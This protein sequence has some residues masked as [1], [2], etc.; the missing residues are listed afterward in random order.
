MTLRPALTTLLTLALSACAVA[1]P[2]ERRA[3][4]DR[5]AAA[6]ALAPLTLQTEKF[7]LHA[8]LK[9]GGASDTL[10][11]YIE[12]D[13]FAW[14]RIGER[15][16]DPTP[17]NPL[18]LR[19][20]AMDDAPS[21]AWLARPCQFTGGE[22][23]RGCTGE[24]WTGARYAEAVIAASNDAIDMLKRKAGADRIALVGYSG[25]GVVA[26][27]AAMRRGDVVW[28][29]TVAAPLDTTAFTTHHKVT[30]LAGSLN[31][32]DH[33]ERLASLPQTHYAGA[34]D[35]VVPPAINRSFLTR[36][37]ETRCITLEELAHANHH[38]GWEK[39]WADIGAK[40]PDCT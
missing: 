13:G 28:L 5:I 38:D 20:A 34:R 40:T 37:R 24:L 29:K 3:N 35:D 39:A 21:V 14:K 36:L 22:A 11:V 31:P 4:A 17:L 6:G 25:G 30:R 2:S 1:A 27:L 32:A 8:R 23:A 12:G 26:A 19:L 10:I 9:A 15:S 7:D 18:A 33:A 16:E